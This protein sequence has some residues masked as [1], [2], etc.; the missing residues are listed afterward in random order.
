M[1]ET[2]ITLTRVQTWNR[3]LREA[4]ESLSPE[5]FKDKAKHRDARDGLPA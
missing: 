1:R 3:L 2:F 5:I 4:V